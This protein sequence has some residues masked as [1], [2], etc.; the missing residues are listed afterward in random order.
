MFEESVIASL[1][2]SPPGDELGDLVFCAMRSVDTFEYKWSLF[3]KFVFKGITD[4]SGDK[5]EKSLSSDEEFSDVSDLD[6]GETLKGCSILINVFECCRFCEDNDIG[7]FPWVR[8]FFSSELLDDNNTRLGFEQSFTVVWNNVDVVGTTGSVL[9]INGLFVSLSTDIVPT[10]VEVGDLFKIILPG[11]GILYKRDWGRVNGE[12]LASGDRIF[13]CIFCGGLVNSTP[14]CSF[15]LTNTVFLASWNLFTGTV[16]TVTARGSNVGI[17]TDGG[18]SGT[19][20]QLGFGCSADKWFTEWI[21]RGIIFALISVSICFRLGLKIDVTGF[22][23][24]DFV[25]DGLELGGVMYPVKL[26][27]G[28]VGVVLA[29]ESWFEIQ[30]ISTESLSDISIHLS[31]ETNKD[32]YIRHYLD[33]DEEGGRCVCVKVCK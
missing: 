17:A 18:S 24:G 7:C 5:S 23:I 22:K 1:D 25:N 19:I 9:T 6:D 3:N 14:P 10:T 20:Y 2:V 21:V 29:K 28:I 33:T 11:L 15:C 27:S 32:Q 31:S 12:N 26:V 8:L 4:L 13:G 30:V 16:L